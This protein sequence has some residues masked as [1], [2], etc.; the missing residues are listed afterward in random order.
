MVENMV[1]RGAKATDAETRQI[2]NYLAT[3]FGK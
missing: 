3:Y 2:I 1:A